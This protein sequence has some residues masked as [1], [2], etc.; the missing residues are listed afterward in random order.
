MNRF[1]TVRAYNRTAHVYDLETNRVLCNT[2]MKWINL[3]TKNKSSFDANE[4]LHRHYGFAVRRGGPNP[5]KFCCIGCKNK[6]MEIS[7]VVGKDLPKLE[8]SYKP[9][10]P[11]I[12]NRFDAFMKEALEAE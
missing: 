4:M 11:E 6:L 3:A 5:F 2:N 12:Q 7:G 1:S 9:L 8:Y 10:P